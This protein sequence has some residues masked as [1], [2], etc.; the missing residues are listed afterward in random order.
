LLARLPYAVRILLEVLTV[1]SGTVFG[2]IAILSLQPLF[3][4]SRLPIVALIVATNGTIAVVVGIALNTYDGMRRQIEDSFRVLQAKEALERELVIARDVQR[5]LLPRS[6]PQLAGLELA[7]LCVP[8]AGV[9]GDYYD[10]ILLEQQVGLVVAD[11]SG[12]GISAALLMAGL[13]ASVRSLARP[14][15]SPAVLTEEL[16][17]ILLHSSAPSR[18]ATLFLGFYDVATRA[19]T[20]CNA[21]HPAPIIAGG[22]AVRRLRA[23]GLPLGL[24]A[25]RPYHE[26]RELLVPGD[27]LVLFTDGVLEAPDDTGEEFGEARLLQALA[28][29]RGRPL[30]AALGAVMEAVRLWS[31]SVEAHDDIT[32][33]LARVPLEGGKR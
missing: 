26:G 10:F 6:V 28:G 32:L 15:L 20:Y 2:S 19:L 17:R 1:L 8:A 33:V 22:S 29:Q 25:G 24:F 31:K 7:G 18:Y 11:V 3:A 13:Q 27:L 23:G 12:K 14:T 4:L 30:E 5:E 9:A 16:N 21:G